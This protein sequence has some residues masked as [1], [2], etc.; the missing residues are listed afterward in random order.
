MEVI[1]ELDKAIEKR[2]S[3]RKYKSTP[4]PDELVMKLLES[5]RLAPSGTNVQPW[6]FVIVKSQEARE[7]VYEAGFKQT[8][9]KK[10]PVVLVCCADMTVFDRDLRKRITELVD[11]GA[12]KK[13]MLDTYPGLDKTLCDDERKAYTPHAMLNVALAMENIALS[14]VAQ[15]LGS[16][17]IRL[18][19]AK[20]IKAL[21]E[22]ADTT[23][24][25]ALMTIGYPDED[26]NARPRVPLNDLI[27]KT[28]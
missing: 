12:M 10:A 22:L 6:R 17:I 26:P 20:K 21:L 19:K 28:V 9:L 24:I 18:M 8:C 23:E 4:L 13:S 7:A 14:A 5:A 15:G 11:N 27:I 25:V 3:I 16:C 1:M 2:R